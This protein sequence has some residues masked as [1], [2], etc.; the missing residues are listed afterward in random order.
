[1]FA[2]QTY[3]NQL[4][5]NSNT[6]YKQ[7]QQGPSSCGVAGDTR[8][9]RYCYLNWYLKSFVPSLTANPQSTSIVTHFIWWK[10]LVYE[11]KLWL[12]LLQETWNKTIKCDIKGIWYPIQAIFDI[13]KCFFPC[14][15]VHLFPFLRVAEC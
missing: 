6:T 12:I 14:L 9:R 11:A 8:R 4:K 3:P 10:W 7:C 5:C 2:G 1:M 15:S 13:Y